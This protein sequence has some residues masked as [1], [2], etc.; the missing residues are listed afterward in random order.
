MRPQITLSDEGILTMTGTHEEGDQ[1]P[2]QLEQDKDK[3]KAK[4]KGAAK[5]RRYAS[6][7][8]SIRLPDDADVEGISATTEHGVLTVRIRKAPQPERAPVREIPVA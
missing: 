2:E 6:F 1:Q 4:A 5:A 3:G 8:R 7:V